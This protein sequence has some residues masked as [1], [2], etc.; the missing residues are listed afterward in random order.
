[1]LEVENKTF[2]WN[3][4]SV[5][6]FQQLI[7]EFKENTEEDNIDILSFCL[8]VSPEEI[9]QLSY[10]DYVNY[11]N[12]MSF[13]YSTPSSKIYNSLQVKNYNFYLK[14]FNDLT[15]GEYVD[16]EN[17]VKEPIENLHLILAVMYRQ[18][19]SGGDT[20]NPPQYEKYSH[21]VQHRSSLFK[22]AN[23]N[24]CYGIIEYFLKFRKEILE[25]YA[26]LFEENNNEELKEEELNKLNRTE[27]IEVVNAEKQEKKRQKW[28]WFQLIYSLSNNDILKMEAVTNLPLIQCLNVLAMKAEMQI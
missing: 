9:E 22:Q 27:R 25:K 24:F 3:D 1:M 17:Y 6:K 12:K 23:I 20:L 18:M 11:C 26:G 28:G 8:D 10:E 5:E 7:I 2:S 16:L 14:T 19:E 13:I 4:F 21:Y 15:L